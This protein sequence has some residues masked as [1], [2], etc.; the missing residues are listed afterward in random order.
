MN[1][2]FRLRRSISYDHQLFKL[3]LGQDTRSWGGSYI[4]KKGQFLYISIPK[5]RVLLCRL[6]I[7]SGLMSCEIEENRLLLIDVQDISVLV[8]RHQDAAIACYLDSRKQFIIVRFQG[9]DV[10]LVSLF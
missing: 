7:E 10:V 9:K 8:G 2:S 4:D 1:F 6:S 5:K 3:F